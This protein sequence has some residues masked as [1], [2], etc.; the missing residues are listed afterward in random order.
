MCGRRSSHTHTHTTLALWNWS[1]RLCRASRVSA[2]VTPSVLFVS[3]WCGYK[4][5]FS[6]P[7]PAA[8]RTIAS[9]RSARSSLA[10]VRVTS[11]EFSHKEEE[12][13]HSGLSALEHLAHSTD[14]PIDWCSRAPCV[15][16]CVCCCAHHCVSRSYQVLVLV[17]VCLSYTRALLF[18]ACARDATTTT[19]SADL[20]FVVVFA[21]ATC[22]SRLDAQ[23]AR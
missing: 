2:S 23:H 16:V 11:R 20:R 14:R 7:R 8:L 9:S 12:A 18:I 1:T 22:E 21:S 15:C 10:G 13:A 17:R 3:R 5:N 6:F 4:R 19:T